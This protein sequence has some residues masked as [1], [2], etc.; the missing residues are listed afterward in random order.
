M[1][2]FD[3]DEFISRFKERARAVKARGLPPVAGPDRAALIA[4][5]ERDYIDF[6]LVGVA[7]WTVE[8]DSLVLR[9]PLKP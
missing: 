9:I 3:V 7:S 8:G 4:Q 2:E 6:S 1:A 5:A